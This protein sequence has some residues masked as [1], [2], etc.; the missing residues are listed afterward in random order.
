MVC[1]NTDGNVR[2]L[3]LFVFNACN[4]AN[5]LDNSLNSV[6][7][8]EIVNALHNASESLKSHTRVDIGVFKVAVVALTVAVKLC[9]NEVP[10]LCISVAI[11]TDLTIGITTSVLLASVKINLGAGAAGTCAVLPE[12]V[13]LAKSY[14]AL[15]CNANLLCPDVK[16]LIVIEVDCNPELVNGELKHLCAEFP[17][18]C[19]SLSLE[20]VAKGE[21]T[22][23]LK[24]STVSCSL[25]YT[26]NIGCTD[27]LLA[28]CNPSS[29]GL[30]LTCKILLHR[31][32][33]GVDEQ[34][35]LV[36]IGHKRV[37]GQSKMALALKKA[38][39]FLSEFVKSCPLH[40]KHFLINKKR[41]F[42]G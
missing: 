2:L 3:V 7:L 42:I 33:T 22:K 41:L 39:V 24:V 11:T 31:S 38:E 26:L 6:N 35:A 25:T 8:K 37:A 40:K 9:E 19:S 1:D 4:L 32:H 29:G 16:R 27:T 28:G 12:V 14:N 30:N 23:H 13:C 34:Q 21:V 15:G 17:R 20:I 36:T 10:E 5:V 18:P